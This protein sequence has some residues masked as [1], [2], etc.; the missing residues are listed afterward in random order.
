MITLHEKQLLKRVGDISQVAGIREYE[1]SSARAKGMKA[2]EV[3]NSAG[4]RFTV[5]PDKCLD[6]LNLNF[7][8]VNFGFLSKNNIVA[9]TFSNALGDE[10]LYNWSGGMLATCGLANAG[11]ANTDHGLYMPEHGRI[12]SRP[13]EQVGITTRWDDD[14]YILEIKGKVSESYI[15]GSNLHL[16]R[17]IATELNST[18]IRITDTVENMEPAEEELM[19]LYHI[20]FG[21]PLVDEG[22]EVICSEGTVLPKTE[23]TDEDLHEWMHTSNPIDGCPEQVF[24]HTNQ[25]SEV[26]Y[27]AVVNEKL[28]YGCYIRYDSKVL[29]IL[30]HWKS[31]R[32]HDYTIGLEPSNSYILGRNEERK[33][34]SL[35]KIGGYETVTH[36]MEIGVLDG[37]DEIEAFRNLLR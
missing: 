20:N 36:T 19:L 10:F 4:L 32:S 24:Y 31:M 3:Y 22:S 30:V 21:Y 18:K 34:G 11:Q 8:G 29:P 37:I 27:A 26:S 23:M 35:K 25:K 16:E 28:G 5:L 2:L 9:H 6:I 7:K 33:N 14:S 1:Y 17:R 15:Y 13:A 12:G